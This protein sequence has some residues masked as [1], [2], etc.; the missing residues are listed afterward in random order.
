MHLNSEDLGAWKRRNFT[1][2]WK[3][4]SVSQKSAGSPSSMMKA[5]GCRLQDQQVEGAALSRSLAAE[6]S[7]C[8]EAPWRA[9]PWLIMREKRLEVIKRHHI[10]FLFNSS[11][12]NDSAGPLLLLVPKHWELLGKYLKS[13]EVR[14][15]Q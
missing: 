2:C 6:P 5:G 10:T 11:A 13:T 3:F 7:P 9:G 14:N 8:K 1:D 15:L 12:F 4:S